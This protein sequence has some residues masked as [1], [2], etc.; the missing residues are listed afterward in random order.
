MAESEGTEVHG[1]LPRAEVIAKLEEMGR[2]LT[3]PE[4]MRRLAQELS[5]SGL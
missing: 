2:G 1:K 5:L 3:I 4:A